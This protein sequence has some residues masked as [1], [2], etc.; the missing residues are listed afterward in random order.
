M[1]KTQEK[2]RDRDWTLVALNRAVLNL[3]VDLKKPSPDEI[4][5]IEIERDRLSL[6]LEK[7]TAKEDA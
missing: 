6:Y 2:Q 1:T 7:N 5:S 4:K 3:V